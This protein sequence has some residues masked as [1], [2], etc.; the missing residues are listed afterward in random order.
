[1]I[2]R[3]ASQHLLLITQPDHA[4][5]AE[6]IMVSWMREGFA[7]AGERRAILLATREHDNGWEDDDA[8]PIVDE[9]T[10]G[11]LDFIHAPE[12][13]RQRVW[14]RGVDALRHE[15]YAAALVAQHA[16]A[17]YD[18]YRGQPAWQPF[19]DRMHTARREMLGATAH[20]L[21]D[22]QRD[23]FIVRM[24]DLAS[25]TFSNGWTAFRSAPIVGLIG[26]ATGS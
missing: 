14:P 12:A 15:P 25:L 17:I 2:V 8:A 4:V 16:L 18:R 7:D 13:L 11:I 19:F 24:G 9:A 1:V 20:S 5:L 23:Y 10:G 21:E 26:T 6:T 3:S 22:L